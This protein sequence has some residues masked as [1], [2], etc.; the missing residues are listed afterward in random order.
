MAD[1]MTRRWACLNCGWKGAL[2]EMFAGATWNDPPQ[3][4]KCRSGNTSTA[5][6]VHDVPAYRGE[7][8]TRN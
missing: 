1:P 5:E 7:I 6:G 8:G 4:P 3:C 2:G